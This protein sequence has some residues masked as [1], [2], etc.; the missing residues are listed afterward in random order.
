MQIYAFHAYYASDGIS[1]N[2]KTGE[3]AMERR[4][5][6]VTH[7]DQLWSRGL[8]DAPADAA[9]DAPST[10]ESRMHRIHAY[11]AKFP[12]FLATLGLE[13][14]RASGLQP[15]RIADIF[16]GCGTV[17][18]E[19]E[20][21][22]LD[23]WGC[24]I[25]PVA[26]LIARTKSARLSP[27]HFHRYLEPIC[28][29]ATSNSEQV[30]LHPDAQ[31]RLLRW[32]APVQFNA[33]GCLLRAIREIVP[34][35]SP[36]RDAY[37]CVFSSILKSCSQWRQR[38][39]KPALDVS[40][41]P[42][43]VMDSFITRALQ[44]ITAL[45]TPHQRP[46]K[47]RVQIQLA[48]ALTVPAPRK[49]VDMLITSPPYVT[50]Y[51]YADLHQLSS[52]WLGYATDYRDLRE[53]AIGSAQHELNLRRSV[54]E[55]NHSGAQI[56]FSLYDRD[57]R[58]AQAVANYYIDMQCVARRAKQFL[59]EGGIAMFVIGNTQYR[60]IDIDNA[61]HLTESLLAAGFSRVR[62]V[63]RSISNKIAT[64]YRD[65]SG[66][67]SRTFIDKHIY[68]HEYVLMAHP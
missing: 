44:F 66:R 51:E 50:S 67:F 10:R 38:S 39:I 8:S 35:E 48:N 33:L 64:P 23:F 41:V 62:A 5:L 18:H 65:A 6:D 28:R 25:N 56:V 60:G 29:S 16:C 47:G 4:F 27:A 57:R 20:R 2:L 43:Q 49:P 22:G 46:R 59:T 11:P 40:K 13:Y 61:S 31:E 45:D 9:W 21:E 34:L 3:R 24:D 53:G 19:A 58:A 36:Y 42:A 12:A 68:G 52:L 37:E 15:R 7:V 54:A 14:A 17:A 1:P 55:L 63:K 30:A 26:T 32:F